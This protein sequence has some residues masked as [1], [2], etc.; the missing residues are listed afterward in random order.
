MS[1][2]SAGLGPGVECNTAVLEHSLYK[3]GS[4]LDNFHT[5]CYRLCQTG[6]ELF[7][8]LRK[9]HALNFFIGFSS[10]DFHPIG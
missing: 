2:N 1:L 7:Q 3:Q 10:K 4:V 5:A 9:A 6:S 8:V